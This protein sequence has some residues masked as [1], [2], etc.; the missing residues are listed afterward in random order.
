MIVP[1]KRFNTNE[2]NKKLSTI[3]HYY[4]GGFITQYYPTKYNIDTIQIELSFN[5]RENEETAYELAKALLQF[6]INNYNISILH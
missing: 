3:N 4:Y 1:N 2:K 6:Y 5:L